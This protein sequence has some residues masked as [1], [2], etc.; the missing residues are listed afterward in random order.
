M[1]NN[2]ILLTFPR[3][4]MNYFV[5]YFYQSCS[6]LLLNFHEYYQIEN[7]LKNKNK[8]I[9]DFDIFTIVR[10]PIDTI[11]SASTMLANLRNDIE[12][13]LLKDIIEETKN[14]YIMFYK[15]N[16]PVLKY[17]VDYNFF[18]QNPEKTIQY[19]ADIVSIKA[20]EITYVDNLVENMSAGYLVSSKGKQ[21]Y[22]DILEIIDS[23]DLQECLDLY[24]LA[25]SK[26]TIID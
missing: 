1:N 16:I 26:K 19:F 20:K 6:T 11:V 7:F 4:G 9:K 15:N 21:H 24:N 3:S 25:L 12:K 23:V 17:I 13:D 8:K 22:N 5:N 14:S 18:I 10:N 2:L